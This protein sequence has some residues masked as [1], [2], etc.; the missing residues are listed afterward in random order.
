MSLLKTQLPRAQRLMDLISLD[1][2]S[3]WS[4]GPTSCYRVDNR[5]KRRAFLS[6]PNRIES[7]VQ[8]PTLVQTSD[9]RLQDRLKNT[10]AQISAADVCATQRDTK[11][12]AYLSRNSRTIFFGFSLDGNLKKDDRR[13]IPNVL[14]LPGPAAWIINRI[15]ELYQTQ[16]S[17]GRPKRV[18]VGNQV[19]ILNT[20]VPHFG[21]PCIGGRQGTVL[22]G[23]CLEKCSLSSTI[24]LKTGRESGRRLHATFGPICVRM[25]NL[26]SDRFH[27]RLSCL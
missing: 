7:S 11:P 18:F 2:F 13:T 20:Y 16:A 25:T 24:Q 9:S 15:P 19:I 12:F 1:P 17:K 8:C 6:E 22:P 10:V 3:H 27:L 4:E 5:C 14:Q 21:P 23:C 26:L